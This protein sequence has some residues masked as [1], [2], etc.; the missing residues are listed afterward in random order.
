MTWI[1][2]LIVVIIAIIA[3]IYF[4][5]RFYRKASREVALVRTGA[6][7]Q[8]VILDGGCFA[9]PILHKISEVNMRTSRLEV[10]RVGDRSMI[11]SDRL[12][13]DV[14][15]EFYVRVQSTPEGVATAAQALGSKS[16]R[17][18]ELADALK[19][20]LVDAMLSVAA[21]YTMDGLQDNRAQ[22]VTEVSESLGSNLAQNGLVMESVSLTRL[23]Q[24]PFGALDENNAFNALGM[25]RLAEIVATNRKERAAI[26][27]DAEVAVRQSQLDATKRR[28]IIESEEQEAEISRDLRVETIRASSQAEIAEQQA[29]AEERREQ[30][31]IGRER[32][33]SVMEIQRDREIRKLELESTLV[34]EMARHDKEI[35]LAAKRSEEAEAQ[36]N[37]MSA[38][39]NEVTAEEMVTTARETATANRDKQ[40]ALIRAAE[41]AEVDDTRVQSEAGTIRAMAEAQAEASAKR[42]AARKEELISEAEG[43][44]ALIEA[45]NGRRDELVKMKVDLAKLKTLPEVIANMVKPAEKIDSIRINHFA[46]FGSA[47]G[48]GSDGGDKAL[49]NQVVDSILSMAI[50]LPAAKKLGE[51]F[52]INIGDGI[53]GVADIALSNGQASTAGNDGGE[54][55]AKQE[56]G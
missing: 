33:V 1:V 41:Q 40:L 44:S 27:A 18:E 6:G 51:E 22:Y 50:Q 47:G 4:L 21:H 10:A 11:T 7:G 30:A 42:A 36:A 38:R 48:G 31:R 8:K 2:V 35:Q 37:S 55:S 17:A 53:K 19:G 52:G 16:F 29:T 23:D 56:K 13:V 54:T 14:E 12:R 26:E 28:L 43:E 39:A 3:V 20:K 24:T 32:E 45:E 15:A 49:A 34:T 5:N 25:R 46:G 9:L